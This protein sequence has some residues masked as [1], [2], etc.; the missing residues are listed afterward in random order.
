[1]STAEC[2]VYHLVK[3]RYVIGHKLDGGCKV[4]VAHTQQT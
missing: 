2:P 1:M 4:I 3:R